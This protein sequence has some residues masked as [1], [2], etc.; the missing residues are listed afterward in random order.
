MAKPPHGLKPTKRT[1]PWLQGVT[2]CCLQGDRGRDLHRLFPETACSCQRWASAGQDTE[3]P[4]GDTGPAR[5]RDP[6]AAPSAAGRLDLEGRGG[7]ARGW[8]GE[9][10]ALPLGPTR[11]QTSGSAPEPGPSSRTCLGTH[12]AWPRRKRPRPGLSLS[13]P[14][15]PTW[16]FLSERTGQPILGHVYP[17]EPGAP[18]ARRLLGSVQP[19]SSVPRLGRHEAAPQSRRGGGVLRHRAGVPG[20]WGSCCCGVSLRCPF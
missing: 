13:H 4:R 6:G 1:E 10:G 16:R 9:A 20:R 7:Q 17:E 2:A 12:T 11:P 15:S 14:P 5:P 8:R 18:R 19:S 3:L